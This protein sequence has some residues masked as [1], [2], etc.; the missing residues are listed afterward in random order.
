MDIKIPHSLLTQFLETK[1]SPETIA[2]D[3]SLCGPTVDQL[4]HRKSDD[5][6]D[7]EII[8]NRIDSAS[9]FGVAREAAAILPEFGHKAKL[10]NNP[11]QNQLTDLGQLPSNQPIKLQILD[12]SLIPRFTAITL[13][14]VE[15]KPS[16]KQTQDWLELSGQRPLNN[17]IDVTNE[18]TLKYGQPV[19]VFDLDKITNQ[20]M[21]L[22][23]SK[24]GEK[25]LTLDGRTHILKGGD[26]VIEDGAKNLIDLCGIIGGGLS[27]VDDHTKN[28]LLF[29][30]IYEP[31][32]IRRTSLY[33][34]ER[35]LA[36]QIFEKSPDPELVLPIL[37]EGVRLLTLRA[38]AKISSNLLDIYQKPKASKP[39]IL[40][41]NWLNRF[42]G[43]DL[44]A[45]KIN[46]IL[47]QLGFTT[48]LINQDKI[49]VSTPSW[50]KNDIN[51]KED[52]AEEITRIY[53]Y[54]RLP[55]ILPANIIPNTQTDPLLKN[56]YQARSYLSNLG[57]TE[58]YNL[59]LVSQ[60]LFASTNLELDPK[61]VLNNPLS[62]EYQY[63]RTSLIPSL[64]TNLANNRGKTE[65]PLK[66]FELSHTY[67]SNNKTL[68]NETSTLT[69]ATY[70][71]DFLE[72]KGHLEALAKHLHFD[73][74]FNPLTSPSKPF[75]QNQSAKIYSDKTLL[76]IIG[77]IDPVTT[78]NF[79]LQETT[80]IIDLDF[81]K[82]N[83][84]IDPIHHFT[85]VP[86]FAS[87]FEDITISSTKPV[88]NL[89]SNLQQA[90]PFII[91]VSYLSSH[92]H[93]H[94]FH[95]EF[96]D[97]KGNLTQDQVNKIKT[98]IKG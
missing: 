39:I 63:L 59:S 40:D 83:L 10:L 68:P 85:P 19:H 6:Y 42:I 50:R 67:H 70:G 1:A 30:Q 60:E 78:T 18:L 41:F 65:P 77:V 8:T 96:N 97:P 93:N 25:I 24:K 31:K 54:F 71:L 53:G 55:S 36:A 81:N 56:E 52:L 46:S 15:I 48:K 14:N 75:I 90:H 22:R 79:S 73:L 95:L 98:T 49:S 20:T 32:H 74:H 80:I 21:V 87:I 4:H 33:T 76:G 28:I 29:V 91:N 47:N 11:Y 3:L 58:I 13:S 23:E 45:Q 34:Q 89:L 5:L 12:S 27:N 62:S 69:L 51:T 35:T 16:P 37:I 94:T 38:N 61:L 26:I 66:I 86:R 44:K 92:Q 57:F 72:S 9:A 17:V 43:I 2:H 88:G 84:K 64:L 7:L 82:L